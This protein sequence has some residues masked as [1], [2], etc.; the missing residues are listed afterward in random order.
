MDERLNHL[1]DRW[2]NE[3]EALVVA[4]MLDMTH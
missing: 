4:L 1:P 3:P 2:L